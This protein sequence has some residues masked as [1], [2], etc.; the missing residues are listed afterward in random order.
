VAPL[1]VLFSLWGRPGSP[2]DPRGE[3]LLIF[4]EILAPFWRSFLVFFHTFFDIVFGVCFYHFFIILGSMLDEFWLH[5][6]SV[7]SMFFRS[8]FRSRIFMIV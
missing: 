7:F 4:G 5:V 8:L 6:G 1:G 3:I 2:R